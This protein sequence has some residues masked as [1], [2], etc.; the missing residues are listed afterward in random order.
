MAKAAAPSQD[1]LLELMKRAAEELKHAKEEAR[2]AV[3]ALQKEQAAHQKTE[4]ELEQAQKIAK[5]AKSQQGTDEELLKDQIEAERENG[6]ALAARVKELEAALEGAA[7]EKKSLEAK[8]A[9]AETAVSVASQNEE[10]KGQKA[11]EEHE[12]TI[13][14][15]KEAHAKAL[16]DLKKEIDEAEAEHKGLLDDAAG[17]LV[18]LEQ[19]LAQEKDKHQAT[20]QKLIET[21]GKVR[22]L[23]GGLAS[24]QE[25][26]KGLETAAKQ[27][28]DANEKALREAAE[29]HTKATAELQQAYA[30]AQQELAA[31]TARWQDVERQYE[32]LHREMLL[33]L[34]QR[35]EARRLLE[36]ERAER[37]RLT[38]VLQTH[39][40]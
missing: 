38:K 5:S 2:T 22:D 40:R 12:K 37:E 14:A 19:Q 36:N 30:T 3:L 11:A 24:E 16:E 4:L 21:R 13:A 32:A 10:A 23:E 33:T 15:L 25:R 29:G 28:A 6:M 1:Q 18:Q 20:A 7:A 35:D 27:M 17:N 34:E 26:V 31:V 39:P 9:E 8:L